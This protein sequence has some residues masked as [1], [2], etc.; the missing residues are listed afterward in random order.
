MTHPDN[1]NFQIR[2]LHA[3]TTL[4]N[5]KS[6]PTNIVE[7][8]NRYKPIPINFNSYP[9]NTLAVTLS[10]NI[11]TN[12]YKDLEKGPDTTYPPYSPRT[13]TSSS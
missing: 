9:K 4:P 10:A 11:L 5:T 3:Y 6:S 12:W 13:T 1:I 8:I 7:I 2:H